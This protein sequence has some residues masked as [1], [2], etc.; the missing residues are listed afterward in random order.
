M[1]ATYALRFELGGASLD[2]CTQS[3]PRFLQ[4][5]RRA[6]SIADSLFRE[7]CV[8][9]IGWNGQWRLPCENLEAMDAFEALRATGFDALPISAWQACPYSEAD[10]E[11]VDTWVFQSYAISHDKAARDTLLW[12]S[13]AAELPIYPSAPITSF[14]LN[15]DTAIMVHAYDDRGLDLI[16]DKPEHLLE[17][18]QLF[19]DWLLDHDRTQMEELFR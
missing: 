18:Y 19:A 4:A 11:D 7:N 16:A 12:H 3:I 14:L 2:N 13:I 10:D 1:R 6:T 5:H 8:A 9:V 15:P 17:S